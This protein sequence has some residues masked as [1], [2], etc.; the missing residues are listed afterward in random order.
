MSC[1]AVLRVYLYGV[2]QCYL[3]LSDCCLLDGL[4]LLHLLHP[5][6]LLILLLDL[7]ARSING[8]LCYSTSKR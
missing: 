4:L 7:Q 5:L 2:P 6:D 3:L 8:R 1:G